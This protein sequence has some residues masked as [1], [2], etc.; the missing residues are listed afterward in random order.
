METNPN[1]LVDK[2]V[3][4]G[5]RQLTPEEGMML[6]MPENG[7]ND[8]SGTEMIELEDGSVE[9][10]IPENEGM[11]V[12]FDANL[13]EVIDEGEL[14]SISS[15]LLNN[16]EDYKTSREGWEQ[17]YT[18]GMGL[19]GYER[20]DRTEP[21]DGASGIT[22]PLLA[23]AATQFQAQAFNEMLPAKGPVKGSIVGK[24]T[25]AKLQ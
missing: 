11:E 12:A 16:Y 2:V 14:A 1:N 5:G 19:L 17:S 20:E 15:T 7:L 24:R 21:F 25:S 3:G 22:H 10:S 23:E 4:P 8:L 18:H 9:F 6:E 13:A